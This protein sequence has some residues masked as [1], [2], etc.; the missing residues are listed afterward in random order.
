MAA[1]PSEPDRSHE[2]RAALDSYSRIVTSVA[3]ELTPKV[4]ALN[5]AHRRPSG[6]FVRGTGSAVVFT[7]DGFLLTNAHVVGH[8]D[9]GTASF[10]DGTT[11]PS[12]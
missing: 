10:A 2:E 1:R 4:A 8:S 6:R 5:V 7:D 9:A 3:A 11:T 12:M